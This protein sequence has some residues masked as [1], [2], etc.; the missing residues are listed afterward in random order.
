MDQTI[1]TKSTSSNTALGEEILLRESSKSR[2]VFKPLLVKNLKN[3]QHCIK[4]EFTFQVKKPSGIWEDYKTLNLNKMKDQEWIKLSLH[5]EE[6]FNLITTLDK[7]YGIFQ[8]YGIRQGQNEFFITDKNVRPLLDQILSNKDNFRKLLAA[9][10]AE[11]L[12]KL[13][14]WMSATQ[15]SG[16]IVDKLQKLNIDNLKKINSLIGVSNLR[17]VLSIW[18]QNKNNSDEEFWQRTLKEHTWVISQVF[19]HPVV[20]LQQKA[21][22]GGKVIDNTKGNVV[23]FLFKNKLTSNVVLIEIKTPLTKLMGAQYRQNT[24]AVSQELTGPINQVLTYK[25]ELQKSFYNLADKTNSRYHSFN[26]QCL[27]IAGCFSSESLNDIGKRSFELFRTDL[28]N[29]EIITFDELF[30]KINLLV[31]LLENDNMSSN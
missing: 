27:V 10:G 31:L 13:F 12:D 6:I 1:K 22:V 24:F 8:K 16:L 30:E 18:D 23:D 28:K 19:S 5:S 29:V 15:D 14:A 2:L 11:I 4:G 21:Y 3:P 17:K 9:G 26:P 7:Y 25:D 20:I